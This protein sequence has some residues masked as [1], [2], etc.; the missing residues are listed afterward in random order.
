MN[1]FELVVVVGIGM[2]GYHMEKPTLQKSDWH[3]IRKCGR[4]EHVK[5][6]QQANH[7]HG[8]VEF[9]ERARGVLGE[10][11]RG[12]R[13][14]LVARALALEPRYRQVEL[15]ERAERREQRLE[16]RLGARVGQVAQEQA[17]RLAHLRRR[18]LLSFARR[19]IRARLSCRHV[20]AVGG[21]L[22]RSWRRVFASTALRRRGGHAVEEHLLVPDE[23]LVPPQGRF[24]I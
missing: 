19:R 5:I 23:R 10:E 15:D 1:T 4:Y 2:R 9:G 21:R 16:V 11:E 22:A 3:A 12:E 20:A 13:E 14:A 8:A 6:E 24:H 7:K 18:R 17:A